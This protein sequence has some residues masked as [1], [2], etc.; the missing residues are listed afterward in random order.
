M[1][2]GRCFTLNPAT[3]FPAEGEDHVLE[4]DCE[5]LRDRMLLPRPHLS[6]LPLVHSDAIWYL[7][8]SC[9]NQKGELGAGYAIVTQKEI[10]NAQEAELIRII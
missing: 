4:Y 10:R 2:L 5:A 7:D 9:R 6:D 1:I 3:L 8:G